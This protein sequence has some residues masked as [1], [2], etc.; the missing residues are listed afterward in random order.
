VQVYLVECFCF[1]RSYSALGRL[2]LVSPLGVDC[3]THLCVHC[4]AL[5]CVD[6]VALLSGCLF[7]FVSKVREF[8]LDFPFRCQWR[9]ELRTRVKEVLQSF[10]CQSCFA[11][12][13]VT[14]KRF[15]F[16]FCVWNYAWLSAFVRQYDRSVGK[17]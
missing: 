10:V 8:E 15:A 4:V 14:L 17:V 3:D 7:A 11:M 5:L 13:C 16:V 1:E 9:G 2:L 6:C 12:A